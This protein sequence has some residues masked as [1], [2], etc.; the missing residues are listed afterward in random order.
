[1]V[2]ERWS[3]LGAGSKI[4]VVGLVS[5][6][7]LA[8]VSSAAPNG[9]RP[10]TTARVT[11]SS[12]TST[13]A[14][15][16]SPVV[17][18]VTDGDTVEVRIGTG[19]E[20]LRLIGINAPEGGE[21]FAGEAT[22][23][24]TELVGGQPVRLEMDESDR[25]QYGRLLRYLHVGDTLVNA[26]MVAEGYALAYRYEPDT[27][28]ADLLEAAQHHAQAAELGLWSP[29]ACGAAADIDLAIG[30]IHYDAEGDDAH[31]L[32]DEWVELVS[33]GEAALDLTGW[34]VK[35]ESASHRYHFPTGFVLDPG[36]AVR[37]HSGCGG[38][39]P[40]ALYWCN[41]GSAVWNNSGDT[42]FV[43]DGRG[44]IALFRSYSRS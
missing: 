15:D 6:L 42:V 43:L 17:L 18:S 19:V 39:G 32:N 9:E 1:M 25:D 34:S 30:E 40:T 11:S 5:V 16:Q 4:G 28:R 22:E 26:L 3:R 38:D 12:P 36:A 41:S 35:D 29:D 33:E 37:L 27:A 23:R 2:G 7:A 10:T 14:P 21:C 31:N 8:A 20:P 44:N 13:G 24:L